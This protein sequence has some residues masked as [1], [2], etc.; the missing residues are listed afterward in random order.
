MTTKLKDRR[1]L[2]ASRGHQIDKGEHA[3][4]RCGLTYT[5]W[6]ERT[7]DGER[8]TCPPASRPRPPF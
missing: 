8:V 3:C 5:D 1:D 2:M 6:A 4:R 7:R